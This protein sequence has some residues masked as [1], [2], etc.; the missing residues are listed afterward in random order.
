MRLQV[1]VGEPSV[2][3]TVQMLRGLKSKYESHHGVII[4][5]R[6]LIA[7]ATLSDRYIQNRFLPD[8]AIDLIDEAAS[9]IRVQLDSMPEEM[10]I[11]KRQF[12]RLQVEEAALRKEKQDAALQTRLS[13]VQEELATLR[14]RL[15]PLQLRY[16]K[17]HARM[18]ELR[19]LQAKREKLR[20]D[21]QV[22]RQ[23]GDLARTADLIHGAIPEVDARLRE[24]KAVPESEE[25]MLSE[26]IGVEE[27]AAVVARWT[28]IPVSRL[29]QSEV[30]KL[31][32][33]KEEL[34]RR[35]VGQDVAVEAVTNA[36]IRS[37]A[38]LAASERGSSFL[39]LGP[40]GVNFCWISPLGAC[41]LSGGQCC[42]PPWDM[43]MPCVAR[44]H[45]AATVDTPTR[46]PVS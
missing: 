37:R 42:A 26:R 24:I 23:R 41:P 46:G 17:E 43:R 36:I 4:S 34:H 18:V 44:L 5:D 22:A 33:L 19:E 21:A 32:G 7:A 15:A 27:I 40:T 9:S 38:G 29:Q 25:P 31:L 1:L 35:I 13:E 11:M 12:T 3:D 16:Q 20:E 30:H 14:D 2:V 10:D 39:F 28:G 45:A 6:A 8:K